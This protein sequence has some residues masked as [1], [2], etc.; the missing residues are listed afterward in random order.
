MNRTP[1]TQRKLYGTTT[2]KN[3]EKK[4]RQIIKECTITKID[5]KRYRVSYRKN[6]AKSYIIRFVNTWQ[7]SCPY[8]VHGHSTCKH[9]MAVQAVQRS[10]DMMIV[11]SASVDECASVDAAAATTTTKQV[12]QLKKKPSRTGI[13]E[14]LLE[15]YGSLCQGCGNA[16]PVRYLELDHKLPLSDGGT[17]G[18]E[19]RILLCAPCNNLKRNLYTISW[20]RNENKRRG[21]MVDENALC[22]LGR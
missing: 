17:D 16:L 11:S 18:V 5:D 19:N 12:K 10:G 22:D 4:A 9:I 1:D 21:L 15:K 6:P 8:K 2:E 7:C 3:L 14:A 13:K 20:L